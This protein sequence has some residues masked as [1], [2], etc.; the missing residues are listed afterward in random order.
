MVVRCVV[1]DFDG[2]LVDSNAVKRRAYLDVFGAHGVPAA[3]VEA[4]LAE[5]RDGDRYVVIEDVVQRARA[6]GFLDGTGATESLVSSLAAAYND[7][8]ET[9]TAT[10]REVA[11]VSTT[12]PLLAAR[13][14]LYVVSDTPDAPLRRVVG[15][16]GWASYFRDVLGRPRTKVENLGLVLRRETIAADA[17][18]VVGDGRRDVEAARHWGCAF[19]GIASDGNDFDTAGLV[20]LPDVGA[21][22]QVLGVVPC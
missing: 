2:V 22:A 8:C 9:H 15:R 1:F 18:V 4:G 14:P 17:V 12:L 5:T 16:R 11:G 19:I 3:T 7:I 6:A 20:M 21:L 13:Y 10:C